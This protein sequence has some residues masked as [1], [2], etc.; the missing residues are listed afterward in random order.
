[1]GVVK[2]II[3]L[4]SLLS[5]ALV[6]VPLVGAACVACFF[7]GFSYILLK[8]I[9]LIKHRQVCTFFS[10]CFFLIS[11]VLL[12]VWAGISFKSYGDRLDPKKSYLI[13]INHRSD[14]DWL[15]GLAYVAHFGFPYPGNVKSVVKASLGKV[16]IFGSTLRLA[17]FSF[18]TRSWATDKEKFLKALASLRTY[19]ETGNPLWF[20]LYPEGTRFTKEK[21]EYSQAYATTKQL[22]PTMHV[23][24]P[25]YKAF[26]AIVSTL[27]DQ[28][29]GVI[30]ATFMFEGE[31]PA[32]KAALA[33]TAST[34]VHAHMKYYSMKD[35]PE[36]QKQLEQW[37]LERWYEKDKR[38]AAFNEEVST[39]GEPNED[40]SGNK[41]PS[42]RPFYALVAV[43]AFSATATIY[44][45]SKVRNGLP[46]LFGASIGAVA[47]IGLFTALNIRPSRKGSGASKK[48]R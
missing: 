31:Q 10:H 30:D 1:M 13:V 25:R 22:R 12:E 17:E 21:Q 47:L 4:K 5:I 36:D 15:L 7:E 39:L 27:R 46:Y 18:L 35:L 19:S 34:V 16:P 48:S 44:A 6:F 38:V 3:K 2:L 33:G 24:F 11:V 28:F 32:F 42:P 29:D 41:H 26:I 40:F 43:F 9:S 20:V 37:L 23:L 8:P 14:V 45:F